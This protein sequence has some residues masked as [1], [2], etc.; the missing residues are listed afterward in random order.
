MLSCFF[1]HLFRYWFMN[2]FVCF[3]SGE[4]FI[5]FRL[6]KKVVWPGSNSH[7]F[8]HFYTALNH[9]ATPLHLVCSR[10]K[11]H[12]IRASRWTKDASFAEKGIS[13]LKLDLNQWSWY[14]TT[15]NI[16]LKLTPNWLMIV[17]AATSSFFFLW[18]KY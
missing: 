4:I 6:N 9:S 13:F 8:I 11:W 18:D 1:K 3:N 12:L 10:F 7:L 14:C 17:K 15:R 2:H 5:L 16:I